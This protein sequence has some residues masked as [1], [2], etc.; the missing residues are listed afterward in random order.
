MVLTKFNVKIYIHLWL[1]LFLTAVGNFVYFLWS[2]LNKL[3][4]RIWHTSK[5]QT[6]FS[7]NNSTNKIYTRCCVFC[8]YMFSLSL[9]KISIT[10]I[11]QFNIFYVTL[12]FIHKI[13]CRIRILFFYT[14]LNFV[15][16]F[17]LPFKVCLSVCWNF[18]PFFRPFFCIFFYNWITR[19]RKNEKE[20]IYCYFYKKRIEFVENKKTV[21]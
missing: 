19:L 8:F 15:V 6:I 1:T 13:L 9:V 14:L 10:T 16:Y 21:K 3:L 12:R 11:W 7:N 2:L 5:T 20:F 17:L 18:L 4:S